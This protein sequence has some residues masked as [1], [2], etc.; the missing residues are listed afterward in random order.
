[1]GSAWSLELFCVQ[2]CY[3]ERDREGILTVSRA[4]MSRRG[5]PPS[6]VRQTP[7]PADIRIESGDIIEELEGIADVARE[8]EDLSD[9]IFRWS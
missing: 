7:P 3:T 2:Q 8:V 4:T 6:M 5:P 1:M 9:G